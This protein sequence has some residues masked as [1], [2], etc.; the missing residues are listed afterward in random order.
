MM[1]ANDKVNHQL[2]KQFQCKKLSLKA[3]GSI[4]YDLWQHQEDNKLYLALS[5]NDSSGCFSAEL[6]SVEQLLAFLKTL[7]ANQRPFFAASLKPMF[8]GKSSNNPSFLA[9]ALLDQGVLK[10]NASNPRLLEVMPDYE[11]WP[12]RLHPA[13]TD[14]A[15]K[16]KSASK[17]N[18]AAKQTSQSIPAEDTHHETD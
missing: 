11:Q 5:A 18:S 3:K 6:L 13:T 4:T 17:S 8:V 12:E 15:K 1:Q 9:A 7:Q 2:V 10:L 16:S 14:T